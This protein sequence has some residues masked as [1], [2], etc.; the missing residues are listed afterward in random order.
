MPSS[1]ATKVLVVGS[2]QGVYGGIE[3]FMIALA[4]FLHSQP[5][6][7]VEVCFKIVQG[8]EIEESLEQLIQGMPFPVHITRRNSRELK[9]LIKS[10]DIVH[11]QNVPPDITFAAKH[12]GKPLVA[13]I[14]NWRVPSLHPRNIAWYWGSRLADYRFYNS[15]F[16]RQSWEKKPPSEVNCVV[17]TVSRLPQNNYSLEGRQGFAFIARWIENKGVELLVKAY[18]AAQLDPE[19]WP[20][21]LMGSGPLRPQIE[22]YIAQN[23]ISGIHILGFVEDA[24]KYEIIERSAWMVVPPHTREDMGLTPIEAR[25]LAVPSIA[26][27]DGGLPEAAGPSA[28]LFEPGDQQ[29]LT[30]RLIEATQMDVVEYRQRAELAHQSLEDYLKPMEFYLQVYQKLLD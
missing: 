20:L 23:K 19:Q 12:S 10:A 1:T 28:L 30:Q 25:C 27:K 17:P 6:Y 9:T 7:A 29:A 18:A 21:K 13:T 24:Q 2:S 4:E 15:D 5:N 3:V 16:V 26:S 11:T 14:H 22:K 8:Y